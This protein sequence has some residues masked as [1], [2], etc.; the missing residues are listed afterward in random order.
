MPTAPETVETAEVPRF[1][2][3]H[4]HPEGRRCKSPCL[5]AQ[6]F[7][8]FHQTS[9]PASSFPKSVHPEA[10]TL[11][12]PEDRAAIQLAIGHIMRKIADAT[13]NPRRAGL[14]LYALQLAS[15]NLPKQLPAEPSTAPT[16]EEV[17]ED[18]THGLIA[19]LTEYDPD[20]LYYAEHPEKEL[21]RTRNFADILMDHLREQ[22]AEATPDTPAPYTPEPHMGELTLDLNAA[23]T[24]CTL[25]A[26]P[27]A[28]S[29][30]RCATRH[31]FSNAG[32]YAESVAT[33]VS[34]K[35]SAGVSPSRGRSKL[36]T[37]RA[38]STRSQSTRPAAASAFSALRI[39]A[40]SIAVMAYVP[41]PPDSY[42]THRSARSLS[43]RPCQNV[44]LESS[45][46]RKISGCRRAVAAGLKSCRRRPIAAV[47]SNSTSLTVS[48]ARSTAPPS[49]RNT[50]PSSPLNLCAKGS[51]YGTDFP[52]GTNPSTQSA[53]ISRPSI[54]WHRSPSTTNSGSTTDARDPRSG[55]IPA[56]P[57]T[58]ICAPL[59]SNRA[60]SPSAIT[61]AADLAAPT[62]LAHARIPRS[63]FTQSGRYPAANSSLSPS[64][65]RSTTYRSSP[66]V[67]PPS[68]SNAPNTTLLIAS[69]KP[70]PQPD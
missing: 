27:S 31:A 14:L 26:T 33:R 32:R 66:G 25:P 68:G 63:R 37:L 67:A 54:S 60:S 16:I 40:S 19:P 62:P 12:M 15:N 39:P 21:T 44:E 61:V 56:T 4:I 64:P 34:A 28:C 45:S 8:Y 41:S 29:S 65:S 9:R 52:I 7:C 51:S 46:P 50:I 13:L 30:S 18:P 1:Q 20:A 69:A 47:S 2:C 36:D 58:K 70:S 35:L 38:I 17:V 24:P 6:D 10:F 53:G 11:P 42:A 48:K 55:E 22:A 5:R 23:A 3:R 43:S 49:S 57:V 59:K